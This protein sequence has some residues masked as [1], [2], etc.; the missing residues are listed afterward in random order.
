MPQ[1]IP[2][3]VYAEALRTLVDVEGLTKE[4]AANY[5]IK[6]ARQFG[7]IAE[8]RAR[9]IVQGQVVYESFLDELSKIASAHSLA[10]HET[11]NPLDLIEFARS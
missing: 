9:V 4:A 3:E 2:P 6:E 11:Q 7:K 10:D 1:R 8:D 5:L